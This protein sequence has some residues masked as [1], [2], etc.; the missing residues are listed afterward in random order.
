VLSLYIPRWVETD[1]IGKVAA[2]LAGVDPRMP[3]TILAFFP[4]YRMR[5]MPSPNLTQML[6][7]YEAARAV[8]LVNIRLGNVGKFVKSDADYEALV[9]AVG[10]KGF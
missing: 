10:R 4:E 3:F 6:E 7:A 9:K 1:Q 2:L 5:D 8:G